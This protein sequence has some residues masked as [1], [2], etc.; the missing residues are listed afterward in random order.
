LLRL[1]GGTWLDSCS[2][3]TFRSI[4]R[5]IEQ[6]T[7]TDMVLMLGDQICADDLGFISPDQSL[8]AYNARYQDAFS[9][10]YIRELMSQVPTYMTLDDHEIEDGWPEKFWFTFRDGCC[11]F[12]VTDV[13]TERALSD[14]PLKCRIMDDE[15][16]AALKMWLADDSQMDNFTRIT[17]DLE[18][19]RIEVFSR[20]GVLLYGVDN[21][22]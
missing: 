16:L 20:K 7:Q 19:V 5:Q 6:G 15:Q 8:D 4:L 17:A 22:F 10:P 13:R 1:F 9:Q 12:F 18:Q 11:D 2:D 3:K 14:D 21:V